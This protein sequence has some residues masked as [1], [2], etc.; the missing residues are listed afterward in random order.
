MLMSGKGLRVGVLF[1]AVMICATAARAQAMRAATS[2]PVPSLHVV[3]TWPPNATVQRF[4]LYRKVAGAPSFPATPLHPQPLE[5]MSNCAD[6]Q[7]VIP[8]GSEEWIV[9]AKS[10]ADSPT[11]DFDPCSISTIA[12]GSPKESKLFLLARS[13]WRIAVVAGLAYDDKGVVNGTGYVYELRGAD[14]VGNETGTLFSNVTVTAGSPAAIPSPGSLSAT[15]GDNRV[16]L[17]WGDQPEAAG[18]AVWRATVAAGPYVRVNELAFLSRI[19]QDIDGAPL[20]TPSNGFLDIRR[21]DDSGAPTYHVVNG[22][23]VYGP[24]DGATYFYKVSSLDLLDQQGPPSGSPV[25]AK[26]Q[27]KTPPAA[28]SGVSVKAVD[29]QNRLEVRWNIVQSDVEGHEESSPIAGYRLFRYDAENAPLPTGTQ[30]GGVIPP[31]APGITDMTASDNASILR[32]PF[33]EQ[34]FWYRVEAFDSSGNVG[35]RSAAAGGH[36]KD[37]TPPAPPKNVAAEGFDDFIR[38]TW[39]PNT[40]PD[41]DGYQIYRSLC[42]N[43]VS[44]PCEP[45][46][47]GILS[48]GHEPVASDQEKTPCTGPYVL[49][50]TVSLAAAKAMGATVTFDDHS[51]PKGSPLCYSYWVKAID[52][53]QNQSG[54]WP[55]P[56]PST[57]KTVCQ[58]LRDK[59]PPDPAV[60]SGLFARDRAVRVEWIGPPVQDIR[61]YHVY[62]GTAEAGP[63]KWVGGMTVELPPAVPQILTA[64]YAPPA[65][66]GCGKI[67]IVTI[68]SMSMG[69]FLDTTADPKTIYWYKV[70]GID[71]SGNEASLG[72]AVP[73]STFTFTTGLPSTPTITSVTGTSAAPFG[74]V[75]R[76]IPT[77]DPARQRGFAV[78]RSDR[79]DGLY[80]QIGT[81]VTGSDYQDNQVVRGVAYWYKVVLMDATGQVSMPSPPVSGSLP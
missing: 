27:D 37:I 1:G 32:P 18:F 50:G 14:A 67:P 28:P 60:I 11:V 73:M 46:Q 49:V 7:A 41:L 76:W 40:E 33:G 10:L 31:P 13:R 51:V 65:V 77:F 36:L 66:V 35:A 8:P 80:R 25:S 57:E 47:P 17:L 16:L 29:S 64:P 62:R 45:R 58:R 48:F 55:F 38:V 20:P 15:A 21:W 68:D 61:A 2:S 56:D 30:I 70:V 78:F 4:N 26:P 23:P 39:A 71:Q 81:L 79:F 34:T 22:V 43:G 72:K 12:A 6:I 74:L 3:V 53:A 63:Y 54:S 9:L 59:T 75:I 44:N 52:R 42:H 24:E 19:T 69:F 5:R